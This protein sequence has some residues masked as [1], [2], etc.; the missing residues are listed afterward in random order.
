VPATIGPD[1]DLID[2][3]T[4]H[5]GALVKTIGDA[6]MAVFPRPEA[7]VQAALEI[8]Q[9]IGAFNR[10]HRIDP[11]LVSELGV[12]Q[13]PVI[14]I[15]GLWNHAVRHFWQCLIPG[16]GADVG[17]VPAGAMHEET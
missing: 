2:C 11:P 14:T 3:I 16:L 10:E 17:K 9:K 8:Q 1:A 12:H 15:R 7:A 13:G 6:V 5:Q 4:L